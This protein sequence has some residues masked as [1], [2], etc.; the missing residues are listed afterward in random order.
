MVRPAAADLI[1]VSCLSVQVPAQ[2]AI[3]LLQREE[4]KISLLLASM[5]S[6][7]E[8]LWKIDE[9]RLESGDSAA[10][11]LWRL[12]RSGKDGLGPTTTSKLMARKRPS[13]IP[14]YDSVV[15][16]VVGLT[17]S[18]GHWATTRALMNM[19]SDG[20][21]LHSRLAHT[22][23]ETGLDQEIVTPLRAFD[24]IVWYAHNLSSGTRTALGIVENRLVDEGQ[25]S[26]RWTDRYRAP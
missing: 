21:P 12:L 5:P 14:V 8:P 13:S 7:D 16:R 26:A 22:I 11:Q 20:A 19:E 4:R 25:L 24:V 1:A 3:R 18:R 9:S 10:S 6:P 15:G 2:A 23:E 17:D